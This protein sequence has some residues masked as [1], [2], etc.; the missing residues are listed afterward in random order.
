MR[1]RDMLFTVPIGIVAGVIGLPEARIA[2]GLI[3]GMIALVITG[4]QAD[5][6]KLREERWK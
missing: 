5:K 3:G 4:Y 1:Y 6:T 2:G